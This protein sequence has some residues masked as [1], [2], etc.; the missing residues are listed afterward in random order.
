LAPPF[1]LAG[2]FLFAPPFLLAGAFLFAP[3]F[4]L[5]GA[6]LLVAI[7]LCNFLSLF[8]HYTKKKYTN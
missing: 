7:V 3:P 5:A 2:A 6:F 4:L 8:Y 1:L